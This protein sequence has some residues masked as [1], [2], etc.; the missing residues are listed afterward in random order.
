MIGDDFACVNLNAN[1]FLTCLI[2]YYYFTLSNYTR[3]NSLVREVKLMNFIQIM[4]HRDDM[5]HFMEVQLLTTQNT[6]P[7]FC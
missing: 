3:F 7:C 6:Q 5:Y 4:Q 1:L 2:K